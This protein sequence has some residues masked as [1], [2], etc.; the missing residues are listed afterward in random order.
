MADQ[1]Q[2]LPFASSTYGMG[3]SPKQNKDHDK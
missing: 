1:S 2:N 3:I